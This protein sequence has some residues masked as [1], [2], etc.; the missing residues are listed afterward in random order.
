MKKWNAPEV[1]ELNINETANGLIHSP[2]ESDNLFHDDAAHNH[3][4][5]PDVDPVS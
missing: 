2:W 3:P 5:T 4:A 1:T